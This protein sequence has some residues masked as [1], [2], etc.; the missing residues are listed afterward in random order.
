MASFIT[1]VA[2]FLLGTIRPESLPFFWAGS[3]VAP[4]AA[5]VA[6]IHGAIAARVRSVCCGRMSLTML[7]MPQSYPWSY[8]RSYPRSYPHELPARPSQESPAAETL[9]QTTCCTKVSPAMHTC[10]HTA[11]RMAALTL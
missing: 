1:Q 4:L 11:P 9:R 10:F 7:L 8:P 5:R 2:G 6:Q 3:R